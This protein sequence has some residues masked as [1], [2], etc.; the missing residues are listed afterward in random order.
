MHRHARTPSA[1]RSRF[2][3]R[4][5]R[6][7]LRRRLLGLTAAVA[8][9]SLGVSGLATAPSASADLGQP[10]HLTVS[11]TANNVDDLKRAP[12]DT[13]TYEIQVGCDDNE[14]IDAKLTDPLPKEFADLTVS[15]VSVSPV[16]A[17]TTTLTDC[18]IGTDTLGE[19]CVLTADFVQPLPGTLNGASRVGILSGATVT[20]EIELTIPATLPPTWASNGVPVVN[21]ATAG[22][23]TSN[24]ASDPTT[25][26]ITIPTTVGVD[27]GKSWTPATQQYQPGLSSKVD[28]TVKNTSNVFADSLEI[29]DPKVAESGE[30]QLAASNPFRLVDFGALGATTFPKGADRVQ[31]DAYYFDGSTWSWIEGT[32]AATAALP[33]AATDPAKV[34]GIRV[35]FTSAAGTAIDPKGTAGSQAFTVKQRA[36]NRATGAALL[37]GVTATNLVEATVVVPGHPDA[38]DEASAQLTVGSLKVSVAPTKTITPAEIPA[39]ESAKVSLVA[40]NNSNPGTLSKL[41]ISEPSDAAAAP[42]LSDD[43]TFEKFTDWSWPEGATDADVTWTLNDGSTRENNDLEASDGAPAAPTGLGARWITGFTIVYNGEI[44]DGATAGVDFAI[45]TDAAMVLTPSSPQTFTNTFAASGTN[46]AG[47][48]TKTASDTLKVYTPDIAVDID[49]SITPKVA[50][51]GGTVVAKLRAQ[52][53]STVVAVKPTEIVVEDLWDGTADSDFWNAYRARSVAYTDVPSGTLEIEYATGS[54]S[55]PVWH[56]L[57]TGVTSPYTG[58]FPSATADAIIGVRFTF[59]NPAGFGQGTIVQPNVV[60]TA[61]GTLR[62]GGATS[63]ADANPTNYTNTASVVAEGEAGG[64]PVTSDIETDD[65]TV[66]IRSYSATDGTGSIIADK[67]WVETGSTNNVSVLPSQSGA[68]ARTLLTWGVTTPGYSS[69]V[70]A[71]PNGNESKPGST[72]FQAFDLAQIQAVPFSADPLLKWDRVTDVSLY[73]SGAWHSVAAPSGSWMNG[74]GFTGYSLKAAETQNTTGVKITVEPNDAA[75]AGSTDATA[76]AVGSGVASAATGRTIPLLWTLRN[77]VRDSA[78]VGGKTWVT[79]GLDYNGGE[80]DIVNTVGVTAIPQSGAPATRGEDDNISLT[81]AAPNVQ[82]TKSVTPAT[83]VVPFGNDVKPADYPTVTWTV[84]ASNTSSARASY[85]RVTDPMACDTTA[86]CVTKATAT[87]AEDV[88]VGAD[89][90]ADEAARNTFDRFTLTGIDFTIPS[91]LPIDKN[92][93]TVALWHLL[94]SGATSATEVSLADADALG[95]A[96]LADVIGVSVV[97]QSTDPATTGGLLVKDQKVTMKLTTQLRKFLRSDAETRVAGGAE[98]I[99]TTLAQTYDPVLAPT[100]TP[101]DDAEASV[102][103]LAGV[104]DVTASKSITPET[105]LE[106]DP[107]TPVTVALGATDGDSTIAAETATIA[108]TDA[109]FWKS[110]QF[111]GLGKVTPPAGADLV[112]VDVQLGSSAWVEGAA[113]AKAALPASV[114]AADY[115]SITGIR[116]VFSNSSNAPF[117]A[118]APSAD[119]NAAAAFT[120]TLRSGVTFPAAVDNETVATATHTGRP[121]VTDTATDGVT[122][123]SGSTQLDVTKG[124]GSHVVEP[125]IVSPWTLTVRN[126]GTGFVDIERVVDTLPATLLWDGEKPTLSE[127]RPGILPATGITTTFEASSGDLSVDWPGTVRLSPKDSITITLGISLQP[128]LTS[129]EKAV[130]EFIAHTVQELDKCTND[131][132]NGQGVLAGLSE[133]ECGTSNYVEPKAGALLFTQ[134]WVKG[135]IDGGLVDGAVNINDA[136][137]ECTPNA[138]GYF[139]TVCAAET[140]VGATDSWRLVGTNTGT[141]PYSSLT[142]VDPLPNIDDHLLATGASRGSTFRPVFVPTGFADNLTASL[143]T[144]ATFTW[145]VTTADDACIGSGKTTWNDDPTCANQP[146]K[147]QWTAGDSFAGD[148]AEVTAIRV[149]VDFAGTASHSLAPGG[150]VTVEYTTVNT[151]DATASAVKTTPSTDRQFAWNQTGVT[152]VTTLHSTI[153]RAPSRTGVTVATGPLEIAKTTSGDATFLAPSEFDFDVSCTVAGTTIDLGADATVSVA[154]GSSAVIE[155]IPLGAECDIAETGALGAYGETGR[156]PSGSQKVSILSDVLASG[157]TPAAQ[158]VSF[159]NEYVAHPDITLTK[160]G[161]LVGTA[162]TPHVGD[163]VNY[164]FTVEN[165]G[166]VA[167][168]SVTIADKLAGLSAITWADGFTGTLKPGEKASATATYALTQADIDAGTLKNSA[169]VTGVPPVGTPPEDD[170]TVT[171]PLTPQPALTLTKTG[172]FADDA[173]GKAGDKVLFTFRVT[174]TGNVTLSDVTITDK[175]AGLSAI[176]FDAWPG[177]AGVLAPGAAVTAHASYATTQADVDAGTLTNTATATGTPPEGDDVSDD[178]STTLLIAPTPAVTLVKTGAL[179]NPDAAEVD[180]AMTFTFTVTNTGNVTLRDLVITDPK[181]GV[182]AITFGTWPS[183]PGTLAPGEVVVA[184]AP[185]ALTAAD[186]SAGKVDNTASVSAVGVAQDVPTTVDSESEVTVVVAPREETDSTTDTESESESGLA[187][188]GTDLLPLLLGVAILLLLGLALLVLGRRRHQPRH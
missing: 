10:A 163:A 13:F 128:G 180:D 158:L 166:N 31:V 103:L 144:G 75:R 185:Y 143:P 111:S 71:D 127:S 48:N 74:T 92:A 114:S 42:F 47:T 15:G 19:D 20:V 119:W 131:S 145:E 100:A 40:K 124:V 105:I 41:T 109:D 82:T 28:L 6:P 27:A 37:G 168:D 133:T 79:V 167:L 151:P 17:A 165:T 117:S 115:E 93:S 70:I 50:T 162:T 72:V 30:A 173:T 23:A 179:A 44:A 80:N 130:N 16:G 63:V 172:T 152:A 36:E 104:L 9:V 34:G 56:T 35:T 2:R 164:G 188:T 141:E 33:S 95:A 122:L 154:G 59:E 178:D 68:Q 135:E 108:D 102:G 149:V 5:S 39:G 88:F 1:P 58:A 77:T 176:E 170:D 78:A 177:A 134:K 81:D 62:T 96:D 147:A 73:Y 64:V 161:K 18:A 116:F 69:V 29:Q 138:D 112:R 43:V 113:A 146:A 53:S 21:T 60:F 8:L 86:D 121:D 182:G 129:G 99:N 183:T 118:T 101:Y 107:G 98:L 61:A 32:T 49:K 66:G 175:I 106:A 14:C 26:T 169:T 89:Y 45:D 139:R 22:S 171:I 25:V 83:V 54:A 3:D 90:D 159:D 65:D 155:G 76:P 153:S 84:D 11:K 136:A 142:F 137:A 52:T 12:G 125:G 67:R 123:G 174:N 140:V 186:I 120:A 85:L 187:T 157:A 184:T 150:S 87:G 55:A 57:A 51:P 97:Y 110:F 91:A 94:P 24:T 7:S 126:T 148:W 160:V 156:T 181:P 132:G 46:S 4:V 38:H